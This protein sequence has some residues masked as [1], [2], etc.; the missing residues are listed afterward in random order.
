M[1]LMKQ[2]QTQGGE[3]HGIHGGSSIGGK[4]IQ[5]M[6]DKDREEDTHRQPSPKI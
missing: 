2:G 3:V 6:S 1:Y 4:E 5:D